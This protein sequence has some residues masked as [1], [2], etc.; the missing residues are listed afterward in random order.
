MSTDNLEL[1]T[2]ADL[3]KHDW[4]DGGPLGTRA[5]VDVVTGRMLSHPSV[6]A[7]LRF[8]DDVIDRF[9]PAATP[10]YNAYTVPVFL[11]QGTEPSSILGRNDKRTKTFITN[12][13]TVP[14][15]IGPRAQVSAGVGYQLA[16]GKELSPTMAAEVFAVVVD[17]SPVGTVCT[18]S[19]WAEYGN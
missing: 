11:R 6:G 10:T 16:P 5:H 17:G 7:E 3:A 4:H 2:S 8:A 15:L 19:V 12:N 9:A 18:V 1:R 14:V 13:G